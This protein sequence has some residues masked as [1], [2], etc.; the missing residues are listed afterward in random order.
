MTDPTSSPPGV[1]TPVTVAMNRPGLA[2]LRRD[3]P[4]LLAL[5]A[6]AEAPLDAEALALL[7]AAVPAD[8]PRYR[9]RVQH[10]VHA[11]QAL[12]RNR[13]TPDG[14]AGLTLN[15]QRLR[16]YLGGRLGSGDQPAIPLAPV[17]AGTLREAEARL[18]R[19]AAAWRTLPPG[20]LRLLLFRWG[21]RYARR[22]QG[23]AGMEAAR[24]RLT[25]FAFL[26]AFTAELPDRAIHEL[27]ADYETLL[28][29]LPAG[30][31]HEEFRLWEAFFR[32]R[33]HI[34]RRGGERWP[35][36]R[37]LL[38][39]AVEHADY[40][41]VT[42]AAEA[43]LAAGHCHWVWLRNPQRVAGVVPDPCLRVLEGHANGV[44]GALV[45]ADGSSPG[46]GTTPCACGTGR[47]APRSPSLASIPTKS[48]GHWRW[49]TGGSSRG[50]RT[51]ACTCGTEGAVFRPPSLPDTPIGSPARWNWRTCA[52]ALG[53]GT[54]RCACGT[55]RAAPRSPSLQGIPP[56][57]QACWTCATDGSSPGPGTTPYAYGMRTAVNHSAH[58]CD[59]RISPGR[60]LSCCTSGAAPACHARSPAKRSPG[61]MDGKTA[62]VAATRA[63]TAPACWHRP[64]AVKSHALVPHGVLVVS[65]DSGRVCC[66]Q[67]YRGARR[68]TLEDY[69]HGADELMGRA[70]A[71]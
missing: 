49:P 11:V 32:E 30:A 64:A 63:R 10:A 38:Q 2:D 68:I 61:R 1:D 50:P 31:E 57:F 4:L 13:P 44:H 24:Q 17:L 48:T 3:L 5:L 54:T 45:L 22:W 14:A 26:Q 37:I 62:G 29:R 19:L 58:R 65:L 42:R 15:Q 71:A 8:A 16:D 60:P 28:A 67:L 41:P 9:D 47:A 56:G 40:S 51:T 12:L 36:C 23:A 59:L 6:R 18:C 69:E 35:A 52:S 66:L 43:W 53:P 34:L 7:L 25:D 70:G 39:L 33:E 21:V 20:G 46:R 27:V 55:H